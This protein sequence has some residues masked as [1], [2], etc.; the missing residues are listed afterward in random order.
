MAPTAE[1]NVQ[2]PTS[3]KAVG[4][5]LR[6]VRRQQGLSRGA[7]ARSAG[8]TRREL[9]QYERGKVECPESDLWCLAGSCGVDVAQLLPRRAPLHISPDLTTISTGDTIRHLRGPAEPDGVLR[10][11]MSM[12]YDLRSLPPGSPVPL[13]QADLAA[14]ADALGGT[15]A[16]I[17]QRL[18]DQIGASPEEAIRLRTMI[19]PPLSLPSGSPTDAPT[20]D[21]YSALSRAD[22]PPAVEDFFAQPPATADVFAPPAVPAAPA[23]PGAPAPP[24][25][26]TPFAA[27]APSPA[28]PAGPAGAPASGPAPAGPTPSD[29]FAGPVDP[30]ASAASV[31][32]DPFGSPPTDDPLAPPPLPPDPFGLGPAPIATPPDPAP[33]DP[34]S[35]PHVHDPLGPPALP[36]DPFAPPASPSAAPPNGDEP[37]AVASPDPESASPF[38]VTPGGNG[39]GPLVN[40]PFAPHW[41]SD[42]GAKPAADALGINV[43]DADAIVVDDPMAPPNAPRSAAPVAPADSVPVA[44]IAW[45]PEPAPAHA[46]ATSTAIDTQP[47]FERASADWQ[48]GGIFPAMATAD[49]GTLALQRADARWALTDL[50]APGDCI[51]EA[52]FDFR[53]GSGFGIVFRGTVDDGDRIGGYSFDVDPIASGGGYLLRLWEDNRQHWRPLAQAPVTDPARLY[54]RHVLQLSVRADQVTVTVD[55]D[56]V[57]DVPALSRAT[58]DLGRQPCRGDRVGVQ[59]W[60]TTEVTIDAFRVATV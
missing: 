24:A 52:S 22:V 55:G 38:G 6:Q 18:V 2:E 44:P 26:A 31:L 41:D 33:A 10:E 20:G 45:K 16:S 9:A 23:A 36:A 59:A 4:R 50:R 27:P 11:Y 21:P 37:I 57:L 28:P 29:P 7:A 30:Q 53:A 51:I 54:G 34:F 58:V 39:H 42:T 48:V 40:D 8:L 5:N 14:L 49:D 15:P 56:P 60:S 1:R 35:A 3:P 46:A 17:E 13:R 32:R 43:M 19:L 25:P 12:I 47:R